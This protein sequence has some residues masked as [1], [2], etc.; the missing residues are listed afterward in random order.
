MLMVAGY[1]K[2]ILVIVVFCCSITQPVFAGDVVGFYFLAGESG[3][4]KAQFCFLVRLV[5]QGQCAEDCLELI[6]LAAVGELHFK[7]LGVFY[8]T[9]VCLPFMRG[10]FERVGRQFP[11]K[12]YFP[13]RS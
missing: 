7:P 9:E 2:G 3:C 13:F 4:L 12:V 5:F 6:P 11:Q 8:R 10:E 1:F